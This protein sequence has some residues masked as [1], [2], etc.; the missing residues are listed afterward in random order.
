MQQ[1][2]TGMF[3]NPNSRSGSMNIFQPIM[4]NRGKFVKVKITVH[5]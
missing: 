1:T 2:G 5:T 4:H 3:V